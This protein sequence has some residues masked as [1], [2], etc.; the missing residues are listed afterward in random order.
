MTEGELGAACGNAPSDVP[1]DRRDFS[2]RESP[3]LRFAVGGVKR[4]RDI[5][6]VPPFGRSAGRGRFRGLHRICRR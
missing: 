4:K 2:D 5:S 3:A 6:V 1:P